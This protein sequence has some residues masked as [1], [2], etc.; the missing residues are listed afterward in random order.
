MAC[1]VAKGWSRDHYRGLR[2][3]SFR[4]ADFFA[5]FDLVADFLATFFLAADF[6]AVAFLAVRFLLA[7]LTGVFFLVDFG[8]FAGADFFFDFFAVAFLLAVA[9]FLAA[10]FFAGSLADFFVTVGASPGLG[11]NGGFTG[12][13]FLDGLGFFLG[14]FF[15]ASAAAFAAASAAAFAS[16]LRLIAR[17]FAAFL[18]TSHSSRRV[19]EFLLTASSIARAFLSLGLLFRS[20][21]A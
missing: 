19:L 17:F 1:T 16:T 11:G 18:L 7:F 4:L 2:L 9:G 15:A 20:T 13:F 6:F 3:V 5:A 12:A 10:A 8:G 14:G 21:A